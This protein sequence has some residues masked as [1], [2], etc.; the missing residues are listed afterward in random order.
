MWVNPA[1]GNTTWIGRHDS[2]E[3]KQKTL[4]SIYKE[5]FGH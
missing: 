5:L 1:N 2:E 4:R 3:V